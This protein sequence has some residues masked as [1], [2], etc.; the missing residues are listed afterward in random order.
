MIIHYEFIC[1]FLYISKCQAEIVN[2]FVHQK[3]QSLQSFTY[4]GDTPYQN[5][6]SKSPIITT[7]LR[8]QRDIAINIT[9]DQLIWPSLELNTAFFGKD[10]SVQ[11]LSKVNNVLQMG[12]NRLVLDIYWEPTQQEWQLCPFSLKD[13]NTTIVDVFLPNNYVCSSKYKFRNFLESINNY[14]ISTEVVTNSKKTNLLFLILN[15]HDLGTTTINVNNTAESSTSVEM[16]DSNLGQIIQNSISSYTSS[17]SSKSPRIYTPLNL[18]NYH[19]NLY[20]SFN[21][22]NPP[23][24]SQQFSNISNIWPEWLYLIEQKV[25]LLVGFGTISPGPTS[26]RITSMDYDTIFDAQAINGFMNTTIETQCPSNTSWAFINDHKIPFTYTSAL[27]VTQCNYSPYFTHSNYS[28]NHSLYST[29]DNSSHL[30]DNILSTIW[31]WDVNEPRDIPH[32][33]CAAMSK[34]NGRWK[35]TNCVDQYRVACR[36]LRELDTWILTQHTYNYERSLTACPEDYVFDV[37]RI[38][39]QNT[40]LKRIIDYSNITEDR[41]WINLNLPYNIDNCWVV[42]RYGTCWWFNDNAQEFIGLI[43]TSIIGGVIILIFVSIFAWIKCARMWRNRNSRSRKAMVK[44]ML[45]KREYVTVP[46]SWF[47]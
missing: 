46:V 4:L 36:K 30:A 31:S 3:N 42:G 6:T 16:S 38:P 5:Q 39:R 22:D 14:L 41:V 10:Y 44:A 9:I 37:P 35:A 43:R 26:F 2:Q 1:L 24:Y 25:Q 33:R 29:Y 15:L 23:S 45:A 32:L 13:I 8:V 20:A 28:D 27:N 40:I 17:S 7:A 11:R 21:R 12:Y 34:E 18:S 47:S 19:A